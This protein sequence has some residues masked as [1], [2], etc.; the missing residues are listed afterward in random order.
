MEGYGI[1]VQEAALCGVPAVVSRDCGLTEAIRE[2]ETG[3]SVPP[4]DPEATAAAIIA[5][6][7][8]DAA[9]QRM[10]RRARELAACV[11]W[12]DR[13]ADYDRLL[14][15]VL[16]AAG[17]ESASSDADSALV[18]RPAFE[19]ADLT[20]VGPSASEDADSVLVIRPASEDGDSA[21]VIRRAF[22]SVDSE[23]VTRHS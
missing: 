19:S 11:T 22:D 9:R 21:L 5:L 18:T 17:A 23:L 12:A 7:D 16:A 6:L 14:R 8:D 20:S 15:E 4:D 10:G 13:V 1:V 2:G 3:V